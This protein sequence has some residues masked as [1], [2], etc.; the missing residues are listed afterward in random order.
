MG[1]SGKKTGIMIFT[2]L[3]LVFLL[4]WI[5]LG[6]TLS[7]TYA[8]LGSPNAN[9]GA[10]INDLN[11]ALENGEITQEEYD[12]SFKELSGGI[13]IEGIKVLRRP[14][15]EYDYDANNYEY[16]EDPE[17]HEWKWVQKAADYYQSF[18]AN[19][20][21]TMFRIYG[22]LNYG[23][24][25]E[26]T[27]P[28]SD[29]F[30]ALYNVCPNTGTETLRGLYDTDRTNP[31]DVTVTTDESLKYFYDAIRYQ[32]TDVEGF[33]SD[34]DGTLDYYE[35]T[36]DTSKAWNWVQNYEAFRYDETGIKA[37]VYSDSKSI[38]PT[39]EG[40]GEV[41]KIDDDGKLTNYFENF[42]L[43]LFKDPENGYYT[44]TIDQ[45]IY[46]H[47]FSALTGGNSD[48]INTLTYAIYNIVLGLKVADAGWEDTGIYNKWIVEGYE[49]YE[50]NGCESS[51][52]YAMKTAKAKFEKLGSYVGLTTSNKEKI[53]EYILK[54]VI[55]EE[56]QK[57]STIDGKLIDLYYEDIVNAVVTYCGNLTT[58]GSAGSRSSVGDTFIASE[59][60]DYPSTSFFVSSSET[61]EFEFIKSYEYQSI[62][63]MPKKTIDHLADIWLDFKYIAKDKNNA[64]INDTTISITIDVDIRWFD[65]TTLHSLSAM[66]KSRSITVYN[67][68]VNVGEDNTTIDFELDKDNVFGKDANIT[69]GQFT[70]DKLNPNINPTYDAAGVV[71][72]DSLTGFQKITLNGSA[73]ARHYYEVVN[74]S[75]FGSYGVLSKDK[76]K[77]AGVESYLEI[78]FDVKKEVGNTDKNYDFYV[79][80]S[81]LNNYVAD[82]S[83]AR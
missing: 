81:R 72:T 83:W 23:Y 56:A 79:G 28:G 8:L 76:I 50:A 20:F 32:I 62:V 43:D 39:G 26:S 17:T 38:D 64:V 60:I 25:S 33:D 57:Y 21:D 5:F 19:I 16:V 75:S 9:G 36:A 4:V 48:F 18:S 11:E 69:L 51:A 1:S 78:V 13:E 22:N 61:D 54:T 41:A 12:E 7:V 73:D 58:T 66:G 15:G 35:V 70:C 2:A 74:S 34:T 63:I 49:D 44:I 29:I 55:G 45:T 30:D 47:T 52:E 40:W 80:F 42:E 71:E 65:G 82:T 6:A 3:F 53:A 67:G 59:I 77:A 37:F 68:V 31:T 10:W 14:T 46:S 24:K 27:S